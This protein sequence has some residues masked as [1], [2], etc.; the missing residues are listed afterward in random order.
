MNEELKKKLEKFEASPP[1]GVWGRIAAFL[2]DGLPA[3]LP[4]KLNHVAVIPPVHAWA[5]ISAGL[6]RINK[7]ISLRLAEVEAVP[8]AGAWNNIREVL[9]GESLP[10]IGEKRRRIPAVL[11]Y[12]SAA[13]LLGALAMV[14]M[15]LIKGS[16][17]K[18]IAPLSVAQT[19][20]RASR[21]QPAVHPDTSLTAVLSNHLPPEGSGTA[22]IAGAHRKHQA[23]N[24]MTQLASLVL[25]APAEAAGSF[26]QAALTGVIPGKSSPLLPDGYVMFMNPDG[27]LIR[28][29]R[30]LAETLGCKYVNGKAAEV[31]QCQDQ[32]RRWR[33]K[34]AQPAMSSSTD[35]FMNVLDVIRAGSD[36]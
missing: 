28:I 8:P 5:T 9:D 4:G 11:R 17:E 32:I 33:D 30:K 22:K 23:A 15:K 1:P 6:G 19:P 21:S 20:A 10:V 2:D 34:L 24:Y 35:N 26:Q 3:D 13:V 16:N 27:Y 18:A 12:A 25:P 36:N 29:S 7:N 14:G 31:E